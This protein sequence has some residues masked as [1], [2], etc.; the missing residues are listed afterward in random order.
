MKNL[1]FCSLIVTVL[2]YSCKTETKPTENV[3]NTDTIV[4][5]QVID[6][7]T[8]Y[9]L[10]SPV[11]FFI[12]IK[13][14]KS[15]Y[16][17]EMLNSPENISKYYTTSSKAINFGIYA[18]DLAYCTVFG[19]NQET[20]IYFTKAKNLADELGLTEGFDEQVAKRIDQN[21]NNSDSLYQITTDG[22]WQAVT[23]LE[24]HDKSNLLPYIL[25]GSWVESV[26]IAIQSVSKFKLD[27][28]LVIRI[29]EQQLLL[30][31]L[32]DHLNSIGDE[33]LNDIISKLTELQAAFDLLYD[34]PEDVIITEE[35]YNEIVKQISALRIQFIS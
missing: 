19:Q 9:R 4:K 14:N 35:Q 2:L 31:N 29:S 16:N 13:D 27:D 17:K 3:V 28:P 11:E 32:I 34:N 15:K 5:E 8:Q 10:P 26:H 30:E 23:F 24:A 6:H 20:F 12:Y 18:S 1:I 33:Q 7:N 21:L 25:V 22:Y